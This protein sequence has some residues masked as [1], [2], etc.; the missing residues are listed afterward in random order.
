[1]PRF[2]ILVPTHNRCDVIGFAIRSALAQSERDFE[3]LVVGDGCTDRTADL[4]ARFDDPRIR[5]FDLPK[6]PG[7]GYANRNVALAAATGELVA[8]L[9]HDDL[10]FPDHL[11]RLKPCFD[12]AAIEFAHSR[13]L[14]VS[15]DG[16]VFPLSVNLENAD[17]LQHLKTGE[18]FIP[19]CCVVY[20]RSCQ[21]RTG[22]WPE[23]LLRDGDR[24]F[25]ARILKGGAERNHASVPLP[26]SLHFKAN[27]R[28]L[29]SMRAWAP[30]G[31][32][33]RIAETSAWWPRCLAITIADGELEQAVFHRAMTTGGAGW[34][35][36]LRWAV[37]RVIDRIALDRVLN[38]LP[39]DKVRAYEATIAAQAKHL[40]DIVQAYELTLEQERSWFRR[41]IASLQEALGAVS[42]EVQPKSG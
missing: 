29:E 12:D 6:A 13:G 39:E 15:P 23:H 37:D 4:V 11:A 10:W 22:L 9:G 33:M 24:D 7:I 18:G 17:E 25:W 16:R 2:S 5:W 30:T 40:A 31:N 20:R 28:S 21:D 26:T 36:E 38:E 35:E 41:E 3:L 42:E 14:W 27:W 34:L 32:S 8:F 1:M 19:A